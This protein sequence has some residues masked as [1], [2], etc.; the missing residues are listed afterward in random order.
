MTK[1]VIHQLSLS[2]IGGVQRSFTLF[3][4]YALKKSFFRHQ[5]YSLHNLITNF[6]DVKSHHFNFQTSLY[7]KIKFIFLYSLKIILFI[8]III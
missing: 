1:K 3:F 6:S 5:I 4:L 7:N 8:F 2:D